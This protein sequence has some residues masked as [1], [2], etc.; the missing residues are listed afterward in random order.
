MNQNIIRSYTGL[1]GID[2]F[3]NVGEKE[4]DAAMPVIAKYGLPL[5]VHCEI[6]KKEVDNKYVS[7]PHFIA[8]RIFF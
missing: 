6:F 3:P 7:K 4:I 5:L 2:E 1:S 8:N